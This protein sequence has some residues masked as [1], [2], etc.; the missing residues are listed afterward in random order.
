MKKSHIQ[1]TLFGLLVIL[2]G[3]CQIASVKTGTRSTSTSEAASTQPAL[4]PGATSGV[5]PARGREEP[6]LITGSIHFTSPFFINTLSEPFVLLED[7]AGF[8]R[9]DE[10]FIF[11]LE[12]QVVGPVN[13]SQSEGLTYSLALPSIPTSTQ[14]DVD[15]D[16][17]ED[18]GVQIFAI[19]YWSN[20][21]G[22]PF[23]EVRDG[24]GWSTAYSSTI[25]D[26]EREDEITGGTLIVWAP[27]RL[28]GFP[29]G[30]GEDKALFTSD[31]PTS[32]VPAGY[33]LVDIS[34]EPFRIYKESQ[35]KIDLIEGDL[36]INDYSQLTYPEAFQALFDKVTREYPFTPDKQI[37]WKAIYD[38]IAPRV[39][40]ARTD[41]D[42]YLAMRDFTQS[43]PDAHV[44]L[45][46]DPKV[47]FNLHGGSFGLVLA[48]L[49][50]GKVIIT[51][52]LPGTP[53]RRAGIEQGAQ[54][55]TWNGQEIRSAITAI[56]PSF[57]PYSTEH[58]RRL[59]Q[60]AFLTRVPPGNMVT[61]EFQ[62]PGQTEIRKVTMK[63][64]VEY[65]SLFEALPSFQVD[66][67]ALAIEAEVLDESGFGYVRI[68]SFSDDY[69]LM[70]QI[71]DK[72]ISAL[73]DNQVPGLIIDIRVNGGGNGNLALDFAGYFFEREIELSRHA[74]FNELTQQFEYLEHPTRLKPGPRIYEGPI[75]VLVSP[76]CISAC[77][78]FANALRQEGRAVVIG[79]FPTAGAY[80]EVG[81]GQYELP[82]GLQMQFPTGRPE[83]LDGK[84]LIEGQGVPLDITVPV[85]EESALGLVDAVL[86]AAIR[87]L[88]K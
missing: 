36:A 29:S 22:G 2:A 35:P 78:G 31:D 47:F 34:Q 3:A 1:L 52:V 88:V 10:E 60:V 7:Q 74:Y 86:E 72:Q 11:S 26:P 18:Q 41:Q 45:T 16:G 38:R 32:N 44:G 28:Q 80:G 70:A 55:I 85:T 87:A 37:N 42:F 67:L 15:N 9:R 84:L 69:N 61:L 39:A 51:K 77:E 49:S 81:R 21:W 65:K 58:H 64:E 8:V 20:I 57:G 43:I 48:E 53:G 50:E 63:A 73:I 76:Y 82:G 23:L 5:Q 13:V 62:N 4:L 6:V 30:F 83:T 79:H 40:S 75:A 56:D 19:A 12:S 33:S 24:T 27:D 25:T 46:L 54:I 17:Q 68:H 66:E 71:W 14:I 59:E